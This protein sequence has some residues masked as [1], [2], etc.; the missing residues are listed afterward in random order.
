M[1]V[2]EAAPLWVTR[3]LCDSAHSLGDFQPGH[4]QE[5]VPT[6]CW[7]GSSLPHHLSRGRLKQLWEPV[8]AVAA[9]RGFRAAVSSDVGDS[10]LHQYQQALWCSPGFRSCLVVIQIFRI[11]RVCVCVKH[12]HIFLLLPEV[13]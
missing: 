1:H 9:G 5:C 6:W 10:G 8:G 2:L 7:Q 4:H 11:Q 12:G 13:F 3:G